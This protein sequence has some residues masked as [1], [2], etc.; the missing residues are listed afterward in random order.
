VGSFGSEV[1]GLG[2]ESK[3]TMGSTLVRQGPRHIGSMRANESPTQR[4]SPMI[5]YLGIIWVT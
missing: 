2:M 1:E 4:V 5:G 3:G